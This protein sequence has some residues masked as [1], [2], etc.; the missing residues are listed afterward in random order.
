MLGMERGGMVVRDCRELLWGVGRLR[1]RKSDWVDPFRLEERA[2]TKRQRMVEHLQLQW[3]TQA[4]A[5]RQQ[6]A[7][8]TILQE[9]ARRMT[10][11][12]LP[13]GA[14]LGPFLTTVGAQITGNT[15]TLTG[16]S[17]SARCRKRRE[18]TAMESIG[19]RVPGPNS[20]L[21]RVTGG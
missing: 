2:A 9:S 6:I 16:R 19:L 7:R 11:S 13:A 17:R 4:E 10:D 8:E 14:A 5:A 15:I 12:S 21:N 1:T 3:A 20:E 18:L